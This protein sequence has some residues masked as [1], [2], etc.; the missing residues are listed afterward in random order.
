MTKMA[1]GDLRAYLRWLADRVWV[2]QTEA[3]EFGLELQEETVTELLL[4]QM[5]RDLSP[6]GLQV[7]MFSK[8]EEGGVTLADGT[9]EVK[10][11]G[12]DWEWFVD[13]PDCMVGFRVQAKRLFGSPKRNGWYD[14]FKPGGIQIDQLITS[15]GSEMNP[16]YVFYNHGFAK[17][18][19]LMTRSTKTNW[20]GASAWGCS[21][22]TAGF[23][24]GLKSRTLEK[25]LP[26]MVPWHRFFTLS[27]HQVHGCAVKRVMSGMAGEQEFKVATTRPSWV[28]MVNRLAVEPPAASLQSSDDS[29]RESDDEAYDLDEN[30][31]L[32]EVLRARNLSGV[33]Y[34]DFRTS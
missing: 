13:L 28:S 21:V 32:Y 33:A 16:I 15:A 26:G 34:F 6:H 14:G 11:T 7:R 8:R 25:I 2:D 24:K 9:V 4:L 20:F 22:A 23:V 17:N 27:N 19:D 31:D 5:A 1:S 12:A 3:R 29:P 30:L 10:G 18:S